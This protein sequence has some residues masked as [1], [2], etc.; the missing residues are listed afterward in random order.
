MDTITTRIETSNDNGLTWETAS[1]S[2]TATEN[3]PLRDHEAD[4]MPCVFGQ[5]VF[6]WACSE[7]HSVDIEVDDVLYRLSVE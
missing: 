2:T 1:V 7:E 3:D 4:L 6:A 5:L